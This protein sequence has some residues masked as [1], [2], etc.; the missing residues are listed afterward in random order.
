[1][2]HIPDPSEM[3][4]P[5]S[6]PQADPQPQASDIDVLRSIVEMGRA[7]LDLNTNQSSMVTHLQSLTNAIT[8][9]HKSFH[10]DLHRTI[11]MSTYT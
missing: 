4:I 9:K 3:A 8:L 11:F 6:H 2:S 10:L 7:L 1:M 5:E